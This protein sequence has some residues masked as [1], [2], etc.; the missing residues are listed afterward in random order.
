[1]INTCFDFCSTT[2]VVWWSEYLAADPEVR[3]RFPALQDFWEVVD[4]EQGPLSLVS[5]IE[6]LLER[7]SSGSS[8]ESREYG[9]RG[10][11]RFHKISTNF[12]DKQRSL[13]RYSSHADPY[14]GVRLQ[15][16]IG[17]SCNNFYKK[18]VC[19]TSISSHVH[20]ELTVLP[21][22]NFVQEHALDELNVAS[23]RQMVKMTLCLIKH[24]ARRRV[25]SGGTA[26]RVP[27][28]GTQ[29]CWVVT[30]PA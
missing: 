21:N 27:N 25:D 6:K 19:R 29:R 18:R 10:P 26:L 3:V 5:T 15:S 9:R 17:R 7:K 23:W 1:M 22:I 16:S 24:C 20:H 11:S 28:L 4:L 14:H 8:L 2:S 12:S 30:F 13:G